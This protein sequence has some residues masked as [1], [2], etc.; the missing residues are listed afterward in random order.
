MGFFAGGVAA[1]VVGIKMPRYCL[2]GDT[3]NYASRMESSGL[4]KIIYTIIKSNK[5][6]Y[7]SSFVV[8]VVYFANRYSRSPKIGLLP[9]QQLHKFW[10]I[11]YI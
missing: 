8:D 2:F 3:V 6:C 7:G 5:S 1:G 9:T 10:N 11:R 4:G